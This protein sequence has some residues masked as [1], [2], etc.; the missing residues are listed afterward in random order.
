MVLEQETISKISKKT[1]KRGEST[2]VDYQKIANDFYDEVVE[3][4]ERINSL[5]E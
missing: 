3:L 2:K 5:D 4:A 1:Y